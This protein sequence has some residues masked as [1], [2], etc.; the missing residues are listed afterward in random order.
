M[1]VS[2][3]AVYR[4]GQKNE[5]TTFFLLLARYVPNVHCSEEEYYEISVKRSII[6][7][8]PTDQRPTTD[9]RPHIWEISNSHISI[10]VI[11]VRNKIKNV[12]KRVFYPKNKK[13][14]L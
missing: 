3:A 6:D 9:Q 1:T 5:V 8:R 12:K 2:F 10:V 11:N 4:V 14:R 13:K 7:D